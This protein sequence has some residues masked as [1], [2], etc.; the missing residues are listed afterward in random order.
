MLPVNSLAEV[1]RLELSRTASDEPALAGLL[2]VYKEYYPEII[3]GHT[4][5]RVARFEVLNQLFY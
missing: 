4:S 2:R 1:A 3:V 5:G